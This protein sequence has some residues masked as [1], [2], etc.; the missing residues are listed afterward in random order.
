MRTTMINPIGESYEVETGSL[1]S[2]RKSARD[3]FG[4]RAVKTVKKKSKRKKV[5]KKSKKRS[6][7]KR[8]SKKSSKKYTS[9]KRH[10]KSHTSKKRSVKRTSKR[11]KRSSKKR[12]S[13]KSPVYFKVQG[14]SIKRAKVKKMPKGH[15]INPIIRV[16]NPIISVKNPSRK[17]RSVSKMKRKM[18]NPIKALGNSVKDVVSV[19]PDAMFSGVGYLGTNIVTN[20]IPVAMIKAN[21]MVRIPVKVA[22]ALGLSVV[23]NMVNKKA[24]QFV[25]IGGVLN[26]MQDT[27][28]ATNLSKMIPM[29]STGAVPTPQLNAPS[30]TENSGEMLISENEASAIFNDDASKDM[31]G[32]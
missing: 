30:T 8:T 11:T 3:I 27:V 16:G 17:K 19:L 29:L 26:A 12:V 18:K 24:G 28:D 23:A 32:Y 5:S 1:S 31:Y 20:L 10:K 22:I 4:K 14:K 21:P 6:S 7:K 15:L 25:L 13:K 9:K 2:L